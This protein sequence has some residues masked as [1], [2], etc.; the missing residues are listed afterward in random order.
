[1]MKW[2]PR[3]LS[4]ETLDDKLPSIITLSPA[5]LSNDSSPVGNKIYLYDD[6]TRASVLSV[7]RQI[8]EI[9]K[10]LKMFQ[11]TYNLQEAPA[12]ELHISTDGGDISPAFSLVDKIKSNPIPINTYCEGFVAS[13]GTLIS[14]VGKKRYISQNSCMLLHQ[15]SSQVWGSFEAISDEKQNLDLFMKMIK[16]VYLKHTK[17]TTKQLN[18]LLKHDLCMTSE[19]TLAYGVVDEII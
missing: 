6:I 5:D 13:A 16:K 19:E 8:D 15:L 12:I 7:S 14:V 1:M 9:T 11:L 17:F 2:K 3:K 18:E 4:D 10:H